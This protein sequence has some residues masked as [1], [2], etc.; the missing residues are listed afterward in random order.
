MKTRMYPRV[1]AFDWH[2][3]KLENGSWDN[4]ALCVYKRNG[5]FKAEFNKFFRNGI[6]KRVIRTITENEFETAKQRL[7]NLYVKSETDRECELAAESINWF[8]AAIA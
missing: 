8:C 1:D 5:F 3:S 4:R 6:E 7:Y 2:G